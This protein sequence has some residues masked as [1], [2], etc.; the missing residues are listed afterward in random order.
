MSYIKF[1]KDQL[2]NLE[3]SLSRE[4]IRA[5]RAGS[6]ASTTIIGCNTRKYHGLLISPQPNVDDDNHVL[7]SALDVTIV[8]HE[9]EFNLGLH[10]YPMGVYQPKGHKYMREMVSDPIP[11]HRYRVGGVIL[12]QEMLFCIEADRFLIKFTLEEAT[13]PTTLKF[14][15]FLAFR[16]VHTLTKANVDADTRYTTVENGIKTKM[17]PG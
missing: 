17:Y 5:N 4:F 15:P 16:N 9:A 13:S 12:S 10:Q 11:T 2:V 14:K 1:N 7:L 6:F 8:Q 3:F